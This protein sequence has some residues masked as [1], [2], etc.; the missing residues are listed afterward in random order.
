MASSTTTWSNGTKYNL[1][2]TYDGANIKI[3]INGALE[4]TTALTGNVANDGYTTRIGNGINEALDVD[5]VTSQFTNEGIYTVCIWQRVISSS[6]IAAIQADP[7]VMFHE[8]GGRRMLI[9]SMLPSIESMICLLGVL[10]ALGV[11]AGIYK[12][13]WHEK[14]TNRSWRKSRK[15]S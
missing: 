1:I 3:Y 9:Q 4:G 12:I 14:M 7:Y 6:E 11:V 13:V 5:A 15:T 10:G 2:G 8:T